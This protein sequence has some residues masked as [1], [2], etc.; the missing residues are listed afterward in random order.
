M[1]ASE[2]LTNVGLRAIVN[3]CGMSQFLQKD[4]LDSIIPTCLIILTVSEIG[5]LVLLKQT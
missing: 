3:F 4:G 2:A 5:N 1:F